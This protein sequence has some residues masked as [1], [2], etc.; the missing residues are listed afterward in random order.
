MNV[1]QHIQWMLHSKYCCISLSDHWECILLLWLI[2]I[3]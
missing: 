1:Y 3:L 2:Y